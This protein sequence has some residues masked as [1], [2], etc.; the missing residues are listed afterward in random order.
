LYEV[1]II[2][3][4]IGAAGPMHNAAAAV[5]DLTRRLAKKLQNDRVCLISMHFLS[6]AEAWA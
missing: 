6:L 3:S 2:R 5:F 1:F 4:T